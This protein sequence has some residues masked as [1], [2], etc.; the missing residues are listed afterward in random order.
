MPERNPVPSLLPSVGSVTASVQ[1]LSLQSRLD[2][3]IPLPPPTLSPSLNPSPRQ[4]SP[5]QYQGGSECTSSEESF[6]EQRGT[7]AARKRAATH[8]YI[9]SQRAQVRDPVQRLRMRTKRFLQDQLDEFGQVL[10]QGA[11]EEAL[12][13]LGSPMVGHDVLGCSLCYIDPVTGSV[14]FCRR[15]VHHPGHPFH[16]CPDS[17]CLH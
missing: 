13:S 15:S 10:T 3:G 11:L 1:N 16:S 5:P 17:S 2:E 14:S 8:P 12:K 6:R 9:S 4:R 7:Q